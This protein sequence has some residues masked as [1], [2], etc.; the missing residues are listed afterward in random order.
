ML[1][2]TISFTAV[3]GLVLALFAGTAN[4]AL[5]AYESFETEGIGGFDGTAD[6]TWTLG[7]GMNKHIVGDK[8]LSYSG[9]TLT[10]DDGDRVFRLFS[11]G[12]DNYFNKAAS[13]DLPSAQTGPVYFSFLGQIATNT[14][15][16][17]WVGYS[18]A[19]GNQPHFGSGQVTMDGRSG[20]KV[21]GTLAPVVIPPTVNTADLGNAKPAPIFVVA[22]LFKSG[23]GNYDRMQVVVNPT[24]TTEPGTWDGDITLDLSVSS[25]DRFGIRYG[26]NAAG[27]NGGWIDEIRIGTT[28]AAVVPE[29]ATLALI[30]VGGIAV[31]LRRRRS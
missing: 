12:K 10:I 4:A 16:Q 28:Y 5:L 8:D 14:F 17:P 1:K 9:G 25:L 31:L 30:G 29:P 23:A 15:F 21:A 11:G 18:A 6:Q 26:N 20:D 7:A 27:E 3:A 24:S 19:G 13:F 22:K 2:H